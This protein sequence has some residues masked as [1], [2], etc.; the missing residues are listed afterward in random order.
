MTPEEMMAQACKR[1]R[2]AGVE[3][4][5]GDA[6][7]LWRVV[8]P[9]RYDD[10]DDLC[11][12]ATFEAFFD[13][14]ER[15]AKREP[16]SHLIGLRDFYNHRFI[17]SSNALDPRPDTETLVALALE[18]GF[19]RVL[20]LGVGSGCI[21]LSL[22]A[23]REAATG[24]GVDVSEAALEVAHQNRAKLELEHR[25]DLHVSDWFQSVEGTFDLIV[26]N[27]P[28][29]A[30]DEIA[31]LQAEVRLYE[32]RI[33][34]TDEGDGLSHYRKIIAEHDP[35]LRAGGRL[36]M[37][38]GPTQGA[39]VREMMVSSGLYQVA[40]HPDMDGRDRVVAGRKR[41]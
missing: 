18:Q 30:A 11:N 35:Y 1:L 8:F 6:Q 9:R 20:D 26:S 33:A 36:L 12:G 7:K 17:V 28:Y 13:L 16:M 5:R 25:C 22:L 14:V 39:A 10:C 32:P 15:R 21:L 27:P 24:V 38:I 29:I 31:D 4:P 34:L 41:T 40:V 37:E 2:A 19:S 3:E 23:E